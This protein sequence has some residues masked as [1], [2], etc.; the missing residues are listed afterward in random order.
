MSSILVVDDDLQLRR[1][2]EKLLA[3]EGYEVRAA[4]TGETGIEAVKAIR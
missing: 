2:F 3:E 4:G 1:S